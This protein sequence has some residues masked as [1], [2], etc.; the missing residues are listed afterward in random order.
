[1]GEGPHP[2]APEHGLGRQHQSD[3]GDPTEPGD[4]DHDHRG[5][6]ARGEREGGPEALVGQQALVDDLLHEDGDGQPTNGH[7]HGEQDREA[8]ALPEL[9]AVGQT[10]AQHG[11]GATTL[12][13]LLLG[14]GRGRAVVVGVPVVVGRGTGPPVREPGRVVE[15]RAALE[16]DELVVAVVEHPVGHRSAASA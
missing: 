1:M 5:T 12:L 14:A 7:E 15:R 3:V 4:T 11:D 2:Q 13:A 9:G 6:A 8:Q 10:P 16:R